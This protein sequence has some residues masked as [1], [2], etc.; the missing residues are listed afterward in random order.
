MSIPSYVQDALAYLKCT[1]A[2]NE[3]IKALQR[4]NTWELCTL[5]KGKKTVACRWVFTVKLKEDDCIDMYKARL[6]AKGY[7]QKY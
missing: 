5:P 6:V 1:K 7:T 2:M 3:E 4:N